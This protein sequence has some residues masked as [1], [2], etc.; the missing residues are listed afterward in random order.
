MTLGVEKKYLKG[1]FSR[2]NTKSKSQFQLPSHNLGPIKLTFYFVESS[3]LIENHN[4]ND[5]PGWV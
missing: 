3:Q 2:I 5:P 4:E 1:S